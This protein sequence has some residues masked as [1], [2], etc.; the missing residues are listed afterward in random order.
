MQKAGRA[1][2][3]QRLAFPAKNALRIA[4]LQPSRKEKDHE[5]TEV[6]RRD[7]CVVETYLI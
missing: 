1:I 7:I 4:E 2:M 6:R 5:N 3:L